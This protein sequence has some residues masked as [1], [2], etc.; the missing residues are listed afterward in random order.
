[1]SR[2]SPIPKTVDLGF[3]L[4]HIRLIGKR[5]MR[6]ELALEEGDEIWDGYSRD[7]WELP[8]GWWENDVDE[9]AIGK[10]LTRRQQRYVLCHELVHAALDLRDRH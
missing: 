7:L 1:M 2:T 9:I 4:I 8:G 6:A 3:H 10:W 5:E